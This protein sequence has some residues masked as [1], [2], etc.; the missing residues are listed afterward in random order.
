M[1][2]LALDPGHI[3]FRDSAL[4][5]KG[6]CSGVEPE[7]APEPWCVFIPVLYLIRHDRNPSKIVSSPG[8]EPVET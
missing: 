8:S 2:M 5:P 1:R 6:I 3:C 7:A 4:A